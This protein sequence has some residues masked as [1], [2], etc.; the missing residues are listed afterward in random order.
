MQNSIGIENHL[1]DRDVE[2]IALLL[3][4][5][6]RWIERRVESL[7]FS[8]DGSTRRR[9]SFDYVIQPEFRLLGFVPL[10]VFKKTNMSMLDVRG[11]DDK[12]LS[13][14]TTKDSTGLAIRLLQSG[15][16]GKLDFKA[17]LL[18]EEIVLFK[19]LAT[20][21]ES[22]ERELELELELERERELLS[23]YGDLI[24]IKELSNYVTLAQVLF[25]TFILWVQLPADAKSNQRII[26]KVSYED[27]LPFE[28]GFRP[29][30][31]RT[32]IHPN[33]SSRFH[34]EVIV[35]PELKIHALTIKSEVKWKRESLS[36]TRKK[37][38]SNQD[39]ERGFLILAESSGDPV[40]VGHI[41][42]DGNLEIPRTQIDIDIVPSA[43]GIVKISFMVACATV[44]VFLIPSLFKF[45]EWGIIEK[46]R[47]G[48]AAALLLLGPAL[49]ATYLAQA[50][51][52]PIVAHRMSGVRYS[53]LT[54]G[55]LLMMAAGL[56][57]GVVA[58]NWLRKAW[59]TLTMVA[60]LALFLLIAWRKQ[61]N[62]VLLR[63]SIP[64]RFMKRG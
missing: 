39:E 23:R 9:I 48:T 59:Y 8:N 64:F 41:A 35:P 53:L 36:E 4:D 2:K 42:M 44:V 52:H 43:G 46:P 49:L 18:I 30:R 6:S 50:P 29:L 33:W 7:S 61:A 54:S 16:K 40:Q 60:C 32:R 3:E 47:N 21:K 25:R 62:F 19:S 5:P 24:D 63:P 57:S 28:G 31:L 15:L 55:L 22:I 14:L 26:T 20:V 56:L 45:F 1:S 27:A 58:D 10:A 38:G 17:K 34:F 51:E 37:I 11:S 12:A 13:I